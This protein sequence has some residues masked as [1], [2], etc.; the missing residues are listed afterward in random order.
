MKN[1]KLTDTRYLY[2]SSLIFVMESTLAGK[3][4]Y[5]KWLDA[6]SFDDCLR[7]TAEFYSG[8]GEVPSGDEEALLRFITENTVREIEEAL[9]S[10]G[11]EENLLVPFRLVSD[12]H[13]VKS[14]IKCEKRGISPES[15]LMSGGTVPK[16][17]V[18]EAVEKRDFSVFTPHVAEACPEAIEAFSK[19]GD[20]SVIDRLI[21]RA[22]FA[23]RAEIC[24][25]IALPY[26]TELCGLKA[27]LLNF[28]SFVRCIRIGA[29]RGFFESFFLPGGTLPL[30]FFTEHYKSG[31]ENL[32]R[33]LSVR[34]MFSR[35]EAAADT[36]MSLGELEKLC[37]DIYL[38]KAL[39]ARNIPFGA[40]KPLMFIV[41][42]EAETQNIRIILSGKKAS[43]SKEKLRARLRGG[44]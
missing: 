41:E 29:E 23:D 21:D 19:S 28:L 33:T 16:E 10:C 34:P 15:L 12:G 7:M 14:C 39:S 31:A 20:P 17:T 30:S 4:Q 3:E 9:L 24:E 5:E 2:L 1:A 6:E 35:L 43:L 37:D 26:L 22:V 25:K 8:R 32:L 44:V 38:E 11:G 13:N 18:R 42:R 27:D 36:E 40:E